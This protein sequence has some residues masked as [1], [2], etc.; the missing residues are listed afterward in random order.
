MFCGPKGIMDHGADC[1]LLR[2][3]N[4]ETAGHPSQGQTDVQVTWKESE[5]KWW[6]ETGAGKV[7]SK[8]G[9]LSDDGNSD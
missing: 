2:R 1:W 6:G 5:W 9:M 4:S 8:K 3:E 7:V